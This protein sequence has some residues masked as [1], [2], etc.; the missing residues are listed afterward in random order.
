MYLEYLTGAIGLI[1]IY[2]FIISKLNL[3]LS[4]ALYIYFYRGIFSLTYI[5]YA[6]N[7]PADA[8]MYL[9]GDEIDKG[10]IGTGM[11]LR[12]VDLVGKY[13]GIK[14]YALYSL[15]GLLGA[16]GCCYLYC[17]IKKCNIRG[18]NKIDNISALFCFLPSLSFWTLA[19][20]KDSIIFLLINYALYSYIELNDKSIKLNFKIILS[21]FLLLLIRPHVG[22]SLVIGYI[23]FFMVQIKKKKYIYIRFFVL[24]L[25]SLAFWKLIP[26]LL[27]YASI[28][29]YNLLESV[30]YLENRF[31]ET[32]FEGANTSYIFRVI[33]FLFTPLPSISFNPLYLAD[34]VNTVFITYFVFTILRDPNSYKNILKNPFF[35]FS[36][37]I[38]LLLPLIVFN[39]GVA[40]RQKWM[41]LPS[42]IISLKYNRYLN[43][44]K[45]GS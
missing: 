2:I 29:N 24:L 1:P 21:T 16:V 37:I 12:L 18:V 4:T 27:Q 43:Y 10:I 31:S 20:G 33:F 13:L 40:T 11:I 17:A 14:G 6:N 7:N 26:L 30:N 36:I 44:K 8:N 45:I 22:A 25:V 39:P 35:L 5:Y 3:K 42:L 38:L 15:F 19:P 34:Y 28:E 23:F 32:S 41:L 9:R